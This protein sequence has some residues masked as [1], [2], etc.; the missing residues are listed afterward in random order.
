MKTWRVAVCA[1]ALI[2]THLQIYLIHMAFK[3]DDITHTA[4]VSFVP[5]AVYS[6]MSYFML[7]HEK[8]MEIKVLKEELEKFRKDA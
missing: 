6:I 5:Y 4:V 1:G 8:N 3:L 2:F 7:A